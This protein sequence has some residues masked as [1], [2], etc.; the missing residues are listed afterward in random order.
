MQ[1]EVIFYSDC[2]SQIQTLLQIWHRESKLHAKGRQEEIALN[3]TLLHK[4]VKQF[5]GKK[6]YLASATVEETYKERGNTGLIQNR[7]QQLPISFGYEVVC[8]WKMSMYCKINVS[9]ISMFFLPHH[10]CSWACLFRIL[11]NS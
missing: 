9:I 2:D 11:F 6:G 8:V 1:G 10:F 5:E 4:S 7:E 3:L